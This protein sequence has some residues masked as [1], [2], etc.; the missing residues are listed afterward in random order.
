MITGYGVPPVPGTVRRS[1]R[2][3]LGSLAPAA[4][5]A[6]ARLSHGQCDGVPGPATRPRPVWPGIEVSH[7]VRATVPVDSKRRTELALL[8]HGAGQ[9]GML[10]DGSL[11]SLR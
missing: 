2:R 3:I 6:A 5:A 7:S 10:L 11:L 4:R 8:S 1:D 9:Q